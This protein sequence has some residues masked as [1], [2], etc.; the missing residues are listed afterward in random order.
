MI[1]LEASLNEKHVEKIVGK[2]ENRKNIF[3]KYVHSMILLEQLNNLLNG[4]GYVFKGGTSLLLLFNQFSRF[5]IDIDI[6]MSEKEYESRDELLESFAEIIAPPFVKVER[7]IERSHGG[8][9]IKAA[10]FFFYYSPRYKTDESYVVLDIVFQ[11][12]SL[13]GK[14]I[15]VTSPYLIQNGQPAMVNTIMVDD[16][17]GDKLTAFAPNT[18]G[19]TYAAKNQYGRPKCTEIIKQL[20]DCSFLAD[21]YHDFNRVKEVY[22]ELSDYQIKNGTNKQLTTQKCLLDTITTCETILSSGANDKN[23][24]NLLL[25]GLRNFNDYKIG[26]PV[27]IMDMQKYAFA[28]DI[29]A[30]KILK[31]SGCQIK[32]ENKYDYFI[33]TGIKENALKLIAE[34]DQ[35]EEF[36]TFCLIS[37]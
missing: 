13:K 32:Q 14:A 12:T 2:E 22:L 24:Y 25:L 3:E 8:K 1:D 21:K 30:S 4:K 37:A 28:V 33:R 20:S 7:D 23:N 27:S 10:H 35:L 6:S 11:D 18:I 16:L 15:A 29:V 19:V 31:E 26:D 9:T 36:Y 34:N 5:S 17:L